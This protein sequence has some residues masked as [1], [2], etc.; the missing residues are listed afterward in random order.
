VE[1][2]EQRRS[3]GSEAYWT[4]EPPFIVGGHRHPSVTGD[5]SE[6]MEFAIDCDRDIDEYIS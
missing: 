5:G 6:G 2:A 1:A 3:A 4:W